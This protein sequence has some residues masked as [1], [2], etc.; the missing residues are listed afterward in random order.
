MMFK[1]CG[2]SMHVILLRLRRKGCGPRVSAGKPRDN[3]ITPAAC[4]CVNTLYVTMLV[5]VAI[6]LLLVKQTTVVESCR[7]R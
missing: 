2:M 7:T 6:W 4:K 1:R 5:N 3:R